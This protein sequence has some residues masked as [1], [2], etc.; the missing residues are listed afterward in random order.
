MLSDDLGIRLGGLRILLPEILHGSHDSGK[1]FGLLHGFGFAG[2]LAEV[3]LPQSSI[4]LA[5]L[6]FNVGVEAGQLLFIGAML[7]VYT[8]VRGIRVRPPDWAWDLP[9]YAIGGIAAF[10][11]I[12]RVV[13]F[14]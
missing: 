2:A 14:W 10:W 13:G 8:A 11:M 12:E 9:P 3:G 7:V 6:T 5:L 1:S 4:P